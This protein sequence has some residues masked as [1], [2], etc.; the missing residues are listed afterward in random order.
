MPRATETLRKAKELDRDSAQKT[1]AQDLRA[2][3]EALLQAAETLV[4]VTINEIMKRQGDVT[5][6]T[7]G[8]LSSALQVLKSTL[9]P[10]ALPRLHGAPIEQELAD[11]LKTAFTDKKLPF[12]GRVLEDLCKATGQEL[13]GLATQLLRLLYSCIDASRIKSLQPIVL[14]MIRN[15]SRSITV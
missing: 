15:N 3:K 8:K 13:G 12:S 11:K 14:D 5:S 1:L 4:D 10:E 7:V 6:E 2:R 9:S